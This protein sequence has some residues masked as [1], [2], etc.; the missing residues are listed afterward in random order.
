MP[1]PI[2]ARNPAPGNAANRRFDAL[3]RELF[4]GLPTPDALVEV[5]CARSAWLPY[6]GREFGFG[7]HGLDYSELGCEQE[8]TILVESGLAGEITCADLFAPPRALLGAFDVVVSFGVVEHFSDTGA[9]TAAMAALLRPGGLLITVIPN[10]RRDRPDRAAHQPGRLR[11]PCPD[12]PRA[13]RDGAPRRRPRGP[14]LGAPPQH[15]L[16]RPEPQRARPEPA[17]DAGQGRVRRQL[18]RLPRSCG[19]S[20]IEPARCRRRARCRPMSS[21]LRAAR[22]S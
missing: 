15:R 18:S 16:R 8:R 2:D 21:A 13:P 20:R 4:A 19:R 9:V 6:F 10:S 3:F 12:L 1:A 11:H 22:A 14:A 5:G 7:L 17:L